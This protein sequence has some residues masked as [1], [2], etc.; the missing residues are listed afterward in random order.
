[1]DAADEDRATG[2]IDVARGIYPTT[3]IA[4]KGGVEDVTDEELRR[5]Y[6]RLVARRGTNS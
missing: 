2:G 1:M 5:V 6:D 4:T 3:K